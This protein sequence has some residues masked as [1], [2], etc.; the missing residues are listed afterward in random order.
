MKETTL[1]NIPVWTKEI[2]NFHQTMKRDLISLLNEH[3]EE[4]VNG[5][6]FSTNKRTKGNDFVQ[7]FFNIMNTEIKELYASVYNNWS[8]CKQLT[9]TDAWSVSYHMGDY[10]RMHNHSSTGLSGILYVDVPVNATYLDILQPWNSWIQD[11]TEMTSVKFREGG[12][13]VFPSF[14][15][16][17]TQPNESDEVKRVIAFDM[18]LIK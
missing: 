3:K 9:I 12:I 18:K 1:F 15:Q 7:R 8:D 5:Q 16:H 10:Q 14:V 2:P 4:R 11:K 13:V 6:K 17:A